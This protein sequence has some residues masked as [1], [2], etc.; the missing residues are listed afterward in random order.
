VLRRAAQK[1]IR[2]LR[3]LQRELVL[4]AILLILEPMKKSNAT[5]AQKRITRRNFLKSSSTAIVAGAVFGALPV[6]QIANTSDGENI[7]SFH[8][9]IAN[10]GRLLTG[11]EYKRGRCAECGS[12]WSDWRWP[13]G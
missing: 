13:I 7:D 6:E 4:F 2:A 12:V 3:S 11:W 9:D 1:R 8:P 5:S 10:S